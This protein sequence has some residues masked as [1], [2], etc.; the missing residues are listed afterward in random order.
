MCRLEV[1]IENTSSRYPKCIQDTVDSRFYQLIA[2]RP[3][4]RRRVRVNR[5][6]W[7]LFRDRN[8]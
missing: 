1:N 2:F 4:S 3:F 5:P 6:F 7:A 8:P